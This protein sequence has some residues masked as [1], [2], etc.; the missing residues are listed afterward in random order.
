VERRI[1]SGTRQIAGATL[2]ISTMGGYSVTVGG[3]YI[4]FMHTI[5]AGLFNT[6]QRVPGKPDCWLGRYGEEDAVRA[7]MEACGREPAGVT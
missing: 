7:I 2:T 5:E 6:Y 1:P 3:D 4:G